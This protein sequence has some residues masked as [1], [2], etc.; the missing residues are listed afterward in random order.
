MTRL[1]AFRDFE[2]AAL[3][4]VEPRVVQ[5][6]P[7]TRAPIQQLNYSF[8]YQSY[9]DSTLLQAAIL[10]QPKN[11]PIVTP[12]ESG[13]TGFGVGLHP[14]SETP[15]AIQFQTNG[16]AGGSTV[17]L[18][19]PGQ[20]IWPGSNSFSGFTWGLPFGWLGGGLAT[21]LVF[22]TKEAVVE[23]G[24]DNEIC[25]HRATFAIKQPA[26]LTLAGSF[27]NAPKNWPMRFPWSQATSGSTPNN[28]KGTPLVMISRPTK[29]IMALRGA[30]TLAA[31]AAMRM[32]FQGTNDLSIDSSGAISL[33]PSPVFEDVN[34]PSFVSFGTSGAMAS[35]NPLI[36]REQGI[37]R[38][39]ADDAGMLFVDIGGAA[40]LNGLFVDVARY[41]KL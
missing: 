22:Q 10:S 5:F 17:Y 32:A 14:S 4:R 9:F 31:P 6:V 27:N 25:F 18:L 41:G 26:D 28:Q 34:W 35:Q 40:A 7:D 11:N 15:I 20:T 8:A 16:A 39:S 12:Q 38:L 21:L 24:D 2:D 1:S 37:A 33:T 13:L 30:T 23:W 29:V 3:G 36:V 19:K